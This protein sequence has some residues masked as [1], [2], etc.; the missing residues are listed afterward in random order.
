MVSISNYSLLRHDRSYGKGGGVAVYFK[1]HLKVVQVFPKD[2]FLDKYSTS[3]TNFEYLCIDFFDKLPIRIICIY[4]P[5]KFSKCF[6][7]VRT[8]CSL[9]NSLSTCSLPCYVIGDFNLPNIDWSIPRANG[10]SCHVY[11]LDFCTSHSW[12]Q[13]VI[14][15]THEKLNVLDLLLTNISANNL[16]STCKV[17]SPLSSKC[18]HNRVVFEIFIDLLSNEPV[19]PKYPNFKKADYHLVNLFL[20]QT[21]WEVALNYDTPQQLYNSFLSI[22]QACILDCIPL[23]S[24]KTPRHS[25][26]PTHIKAMVKDKKRLYKRLK[27]DNSL[28]DQYKSLSRDYE[29]AVKSWTNKIENNVCV[30][31]SGK[32]FYS[33]VNNKL[34]TKSV[35]P[36]MYNAST[37]TLCF[38]DYEKASLFNSYFHSV[39]TNDD[40]Q[41]LSIHPRSFIPMCEFNISPN[42]ILAIADGMKDKITRTPDN[43][44]SYFIKR[45]IRSI[46]YPLSIIFNKFLRLHFVP[47]QWKV[48][49]I[50]PIHKKSNKSLPNNYRPIALTSSFSRMF[51]SLVHKRILSHLLYNSLISPAQ[52]GFVPGKSS[53]SQL[54]STLNDW[55]QALSS[56]S[57]IN[58]IYTD[59]AKAFDS[60]SHRKLIAIIRSYGISFDVTS[61]LKEFLTDRQQQVCINSSSSSYLPVLSGVPQG[62]VIGPLLF[63]MFFDDVTKSVPQIQGASGIKLFA[64]DTKLYATN[65]TD[66]QLYTDQMISWMKEHQLSIA[67][68]KCFSLCISKSKPKVPPPVFSIDSHPIPVLSLAKDLGIIVTDDL[69]WSTHIESITS[70]AS[71]CAYRILK[72]FKTRNIWILLRLF[73]TYVRPKLEYNT[74]VWCPHLDKDVMKLESVQRVFLRKVFMRCQIKFDSYID[75]LQKVNLHSLE[76]R[77]VINDLIFLFKII[78]KLCDLDFFDYFYFLPAH[79]N[80]RRNSK[81]IGVKSMPNLKCQFYRKS[82]FLRSSQYWNRLPEDI[83][84]SPNLISF[85]H[86]LHRFPLHTVIQLHCKY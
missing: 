48:S 69:K 52:F 84:N 66:L 12:T 57:S 25:Q 50:I 43:V 21:N 73:K 36:P 68:Q 31:P 13:H 10:D 53:C 67:H 27:A 49:Q 58:V 29:L 22:L 72:C 30:N 1:Q 55:Y 44:P 19:K 38:S 2:S 56:H 28:K 37:E 79:Y 71:A 23:H 80:L 45:V 46:V 18:D 34:K 39:F 42:D 32:K 16:L 77:R 20:C 82:F 83:V 11:F 17:T 41:T 60:V 24:T 35:I 63:L 15:S 75:R 74:P 5:P 6:D 4:L 62:S 51:E 47:S 3:L 9:I 85:K 64:D 26:L 33:F 76:R 81:Q 70:K 61:W 54:L 7:T 59:I 8:L 65:S 40:S 78:H 14:E 86:R